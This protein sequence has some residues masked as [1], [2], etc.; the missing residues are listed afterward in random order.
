MQQSAEITHFRHGIDFD[1]VVADTTELKTR[2]ARKFFPRKLTPPKGMFRQDVV[3]R[4][5]SERDP[6]RF[7]QRQYNRLKEVVFTDPKVGINLHEVPHAFETIRRLKEEGHTV[8]IVSNRTP[9]AAEVAAQWLKKNEIQLVFYPLFVHHDDK[10][11]VIETLDLMSYTDNDIENLLPLKGK[12]PH[13]FLFH[14]EHNADVDEPGITRVHGW[15]E[16]R[17]RIRA[18]K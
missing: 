15:E 2:I 4:K 10:R 17:G 1:D 9:R 14:T 11:E 8:M 7:T 12:V 6:S 3:V 16:L 5:D 13:L 18:I